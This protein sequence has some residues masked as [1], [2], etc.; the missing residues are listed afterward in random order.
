MYVLYIM[1][2]DTFNNQVYMISDTS[3]RVVWDFLY[4]Q[5]VLLNVNRFPPDIP[6]S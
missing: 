6:M 5:R 1:T 3:G 2:Y 4:R